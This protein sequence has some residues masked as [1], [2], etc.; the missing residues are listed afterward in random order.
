MYHMTRTLEQGNEFWE[1]GRIEYKR[2]GWKSTKENE[3]CG[4]NPFLIN[5][6]TKNILSQNVRNTYS[7]L[8]IH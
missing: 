8:F 4:Q 6:F 5:S 2:E 3:K 7:I 1:E